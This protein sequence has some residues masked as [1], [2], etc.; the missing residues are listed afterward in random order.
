MI[1]KQGTAVRRIS[2]DPENAEFIEGK[3]EEIIPKMYKEEKRA[4][5]IVVDPPRKGCDEILL[6][7]MVNMKPSKIIYVCRWVNRRL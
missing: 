4:D 1:A 7:T 3:V 5:V 2:L 6:E